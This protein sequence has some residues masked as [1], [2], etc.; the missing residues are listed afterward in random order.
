MPFSQ[1]SQITSIIQYIEQENP[2]TLL[3][4]GTGMG[5]YGFLSRTNLENINLFKIDDGIAAQRPKQDWQVRIDGIEGFKEYVTPIHDY[6]YNKMMIGDALDILPTI[7][8]NSYELIIAVDILEHFTKAEGKT[9]LSQLK[10][11]ANKSVLVSTPKIFI[12]QEI[13]ANPYE[14]HRSLWEKDEL[15]SNGFPNILDNEES[16]IVCK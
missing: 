3:D 14:K 8:N 2:K 15:I 7:N 16:W 9:F 1:S 5:Q 11:I 6:C 13:E 12:A 10:R 4:V